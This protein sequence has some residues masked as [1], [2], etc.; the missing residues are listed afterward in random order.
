M[1]SKHGNKALGNLNGLTLRSSGIG[2]EDMLQI[3]P[4]NHQKQEI[5][6]I[7]KLKD[8]NFLRKQ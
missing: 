1:N 7:S 4:S 3:W 8:H 6:S 5:A 2:T